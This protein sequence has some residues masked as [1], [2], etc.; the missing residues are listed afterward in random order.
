MGPTANKL[1]NLQL[2]LIKLFH[3]NLNEKQLT[4]L[5][6]YFQ[7]RYEVTVLPEADLETSFPGIE[8][9]QIFDLFMN[10]AGMKCDIPFFRLNTYQLMRFSHKLSSFKA[11][12]L[13]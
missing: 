9:K 2:E 4:E 6:F 3:Y 12:C 7:S 8:I 5:W 1:T 13:R 11:N 10:S